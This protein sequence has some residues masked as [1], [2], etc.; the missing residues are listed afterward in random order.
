[1]PESPLDR[2]RAKDK[3]TGYDRTISRAELSHGN[4]QVLKQDA[5]DH[6]GADIP[7]DYHLD[8]PAP[9]GQQA[10]TQKES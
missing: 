1:M 10:T 7:P 2:I 6:T 9:S 8:S 4:Y 3:D 5:V